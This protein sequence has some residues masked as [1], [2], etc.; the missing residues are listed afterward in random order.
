MRLSRQIIFYVLAGFLFTVLAAFAVN[1]LIFLASKLNDAFSAQ[2]I[3]AEQ[4]PTFDKESFLALDL[5]KER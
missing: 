4:I 3:E 5:I 2:G 1:N